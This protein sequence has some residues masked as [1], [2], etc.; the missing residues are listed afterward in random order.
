VSYR[1]TNFC[2]FL[3]YNSAQD[4]NVTGN[5]TVYTIIFDTEVFNYLGAYNNSTGVFTAP[6]TGLYLFCGHIASSGYATT[7]SPIL[8]E[9][10]TTLRTFRLFYSTGV[11]L[12]P[13]AYGMPFAVLCN[14]TAGNTASIVL[15]VSGSVM[16]AVDVDGAA[17]PIT[18][19][20]GKQVI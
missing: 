15:T 13:T 12:I 9:L 3:S 1:N 8:L 17:S 11:N 6:E 18:Y 14:M 20:S 16:D 7:N 2:R 5:G 19:F 4:T 10:V